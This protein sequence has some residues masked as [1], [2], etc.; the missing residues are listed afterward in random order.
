MSKPFSKTGFGQF[1]KKVKNAMPDIADVA[2]DAATGGPMAAV[3][4]IAEKLKAA[5]DKDTATAQLHEEFELR[6]ME[7]EQ[8]AREAE[9]ERQRMQLDDVADARS[10]EKV[11]R[12]TVGVV[13][14]NVAA[15]I[16]ILA[17]CGVLVGLMMI[18]QVA[19]KELL[20]YM[21]GALSG[22]VLQVFS[23]WFGS[24][25]G[26]HKR[27]DVQAIKSLSR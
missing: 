27:N 3:Q 5:K 9:L 24:S 22:V 19:N 12:N 11:L 15:S 2:L 26:E 6:R 21:L 4:S 10:R 1:L 16:V 13:V 25:Q 17:F 18:E 20:Y 8:E 7:F 23:Y 14:Q